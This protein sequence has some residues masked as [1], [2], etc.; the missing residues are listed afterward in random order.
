MRTGE[1]SVVRRFAD[2]WPPHSRRSNHS[3]V[4]GAVVVGPSWSALVIFGVGA[5][6]LGL[7]DTYV[8]R[9]RENPGDYED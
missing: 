6:M 5:V 8:Q 7:V 2:R 4:I 1:N 3:W 9:I